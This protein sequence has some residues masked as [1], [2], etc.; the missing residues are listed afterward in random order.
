[1]S[2]LLQQEKKKSS[3]LAEISPEG[4]IWRCSHTDTTLLKLQR[5]RLLYSFDCMCP[6][7]HADHLRLKHVRKHSGR[8]LHQ[9]V[10]AEEEDLATQL[11]GAVVHSDSG[12]SGLL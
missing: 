6:L 10:P 5:R 9:T 11:Q 12:Q 7:M 4:A 1:M 3:E 2:Q 8:A